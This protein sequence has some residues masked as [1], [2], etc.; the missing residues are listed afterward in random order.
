M[1][2]GIH[3]FFQRAQPGTSTLVAQ[4][5]QCAA[6]PSD[7]G[8][9]PLPRSVST[10]VTVGMEVMHLASRKVGKVSRLARNTKGMIEATVTLPT[11]EKLTGS[12]ILG[13]DFEKSQAVSSKGNTSGSAS[14]GGPQETP[15]SFG[16]WDAFMG[17]SEKQNTAEPLR[18]ERPIQLLPRNNTHLPSGSVPRGS[19]KP[20]EAT[21]NHAVSNHLSRETD[22]M[23]RQKFVFDFEE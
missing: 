2:T 23:P 4:G 16:K 20:R 5:A 10:M 7:R 15:K 19:V 22:A 11:G 14:H 3:S 9:K 8:G 21:A 18:D 17:P 12:P 1:Q 6:A 13:R